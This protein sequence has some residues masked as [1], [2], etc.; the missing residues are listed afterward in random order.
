M[1]DLRK[2][3]PHQ[4]AP[5]LFH[6]SLDNNTATAVAISP[7]YYFAALSFDKTIAYY[8]FKGGEGGVYFREVKRFGRNIYKGA[9]GALAV[10]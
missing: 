4:P 5:D 1:Y 3:K 9:Q 2:W 6:T 8:E 7:N 10:G